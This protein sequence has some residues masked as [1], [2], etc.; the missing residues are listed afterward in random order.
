MSFKDFSNA[1]RKSIGKRKS[2][3]SYGLKDAFHYYM[4]NSKYRLTRVEFMKVITTIN[5]L[6]KEELLKGGS[7]SFPLNMGT[8]EIRKTIRTPKL[9]NGKVKITYPIDWASTL[10]LWYEDPKAKEAKTLVRLE[11]PIVYQFFYKKERADYYNRMFYRFNVSR[12]LKQRLKDNINNGIIIDA[13][14]IN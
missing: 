10:K 13:Y 14:P 2:S 4:N 11:S 3:K 7:F 12:G 1:I 9:V 6:V 8:I 5:D